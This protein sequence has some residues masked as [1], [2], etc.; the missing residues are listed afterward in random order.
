MFAKKHSSSG[1]CDGASDSSSSSSST[2]T[3]CVRDVSTKTTNLPP[4]ERQLPDGTC[5]AGYHLVDLLRN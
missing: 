1:S 2:G 3:V 4:I 5:S